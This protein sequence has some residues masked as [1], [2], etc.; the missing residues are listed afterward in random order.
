[1][2]DHSNALVFVLSGCRSS[3]K[4]LDS[5]FLAALRNMLLKHGNFKKEQTVICIMVEKL[6]TAKLNCSEKLGE[7]V[8]GRRTSSGCKKAGWIMKCVAT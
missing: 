4:K 5:V 2:L 1:M 8:R 6:L 7:G 3:G